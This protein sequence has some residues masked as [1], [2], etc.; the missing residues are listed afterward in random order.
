MLTC[1]GLHTH[2]SA[3]LSRISTRFPATTTR[4]FLPYAIPSRHKIF[5]RQ[6]SSLALRQNSL[7]NVSSQQ[8]KNCIISSLQHLK[9]IR[10]FSI[11]FLNCLHKISDSKI[12]TKC[13]QIQRV[14][15]KINSTVFPPV[16]SIEIVFKN[17]LQLIKFFSK[18]PEFASIFLLGKIEHKILSSTRVIKQGLRRT[19]VAIKILI[20]EKQIPTVL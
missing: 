7:A 5:S 16:T 3:I 13:H 10:P 6:F 20:N 4:P 8:E 9:N 17:S 1:Q 18:N 19:K 12:S 14:V 2:I 11:G 15:I